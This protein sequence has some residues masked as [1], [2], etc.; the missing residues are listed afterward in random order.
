MF[1][2]ECLEERN[3]LSHTPMLARVL[4]PPANPPLP[5]VTVI[6]GTLHLN[7][8]SAPVFAQASP[9]QIAYSGNGTSTPGNVGNVT[10]GMQQ[11]ETNVPGASVTTKNITNGRGLLIDMWGEQAQV[12]YTGQETFPRHKQHPITLTGTIHSGTGRFEN[13][14]GT[15][16]ATGRVVDI[17][18][19]SLKF[20]LTPKK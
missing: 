10:F 12:I 2:L 17:N 4:V 16:T 11:T 19:L 15:F 3:L 7:R 9:G 8:A 18:T 1:R 5:A 20:T 13:A 6:K 14:T